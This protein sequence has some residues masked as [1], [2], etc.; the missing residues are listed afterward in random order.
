M[1][2]NEDPLITLIPKSQVAPPFLPPFQIYKS[3]F[4]VNFPPDIPL[5]LPGTLFHNA[6]MAQYFS[7]D[8][9]VICSKFSPKHTVGFL[10]TSPHSVAWV[11]ARYQL[12]GG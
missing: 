5:A 11:K 1:H 6:L 4:P 10:F 7:P 12:G 2:S 3:L 8:G 9:V